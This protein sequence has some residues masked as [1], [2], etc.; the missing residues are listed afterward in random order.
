MPE[1]SPTVLDHF[2]HPRNLGDLPDAD[3]VAEVENP[4]CGDRTRLAIRVRDGRIAAARFRTEG[5]PAAIAASSMTTELILG[6][7]LEEAATLRDEDVATALGGLPRNKMH[8]SV[9]AEDVIQAVIEQY[10]ANTR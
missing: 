10:Q 9:L 5:C 2:Q 8:C 3:A 7:T 4:A 1:Y 6:R